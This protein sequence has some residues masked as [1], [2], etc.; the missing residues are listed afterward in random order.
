VQARQATDPKVRLA[1]VK[2]AIEETRHAELARDLDIWFRSQLSEEDNQ[3]LD[4][5]RDRAVKQLVARIDGDQRPRF[6]EAGLP[7]AV[8]EQ[9]MIRSLASTLWQSVN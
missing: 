5:A 1:M 9:E 3:R 8:E 2:I 4:Q 7:S 6:P